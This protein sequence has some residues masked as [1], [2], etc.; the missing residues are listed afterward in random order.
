[1]LFRVYRADIVW[2]S[3]PAEERLHNQRTTDNMTTHR[4]IA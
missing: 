1:M 4:L 3:A 2:T